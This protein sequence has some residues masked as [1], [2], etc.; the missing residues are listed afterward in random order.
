MSRSSYIRFESNTKRDSSTQRTR[1]KRKRRYKLTNKR[2]LIFTAFILLMVSFNVGVN[3]PQVQGG[4]LPAAEYSYV[5]FIV[6]DHWADVPEIGAEILSNRI[7]VPINF[8]SQNLSMKYEISDNKVRITYNKKTMDIA[9]GNSEDGLAVKL[10]D[11]V[12]VPIRQI[13]DFYGYQINV[14]KNNDFV[15]IKNEQAKLS[16]E[17]AVKKY[18]KNYLK[19]IVVPKGKTVYLTFDDGPSKYT[20]NILSMLDEYGYYAT[21][22]CHGSQMEKFPGMLKKI[23]DAG[24][25][26]GLHSMTHIKNSFYASPDAA[27]MEMDQ[28]NDVLQSIVGYKVRFTRTP[29]GS[30]PYFTED[31]RKL[32]A[33]KEYKVWDWNIDSYDASS[34]TVSAEN[35]SSKTINQ[36]KNLKSDAIIL[37]H[38]KK[39]T[40]DALP[41]ILRYI[42]EKGYVCKPIFDEDEPYNFFNKRT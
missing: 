34:N 16:D 26:I 28:A 27:L 15:R 13:C 17:E 18:N 38:N 1:V 6:Q 8:I 35:V 39:V 30:Y 42:K 24:H 11:R 29:F 12:F 41:E 5:K 20:E 40:A 19:S 2:R 23:S 10:Y 36:L 37:L 25:S 7:Y 32:F 9:Y 3:A 21:F 14:I 4:Y 22:F 33:E 31:F